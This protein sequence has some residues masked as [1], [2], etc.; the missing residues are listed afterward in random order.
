METNSHGQSYTICWTSIEADACYPPCLDGSYP[1]RPTLGQNG[2]T[3]NNRLIVV[4]FVGMALVWVVVWAI[5]MNA[6]GMNMR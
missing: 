2:S 6:Y 1:A 5:V 3:M 4:C